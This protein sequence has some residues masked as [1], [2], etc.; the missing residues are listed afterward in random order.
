M[1]PKLALPTHLVLARSN[2]VPGA[3]VHRVFEA[4]LLHAITFH[5]RS[6]PFGTLTVFFELPAAAG[7]QSVVLGT[8]L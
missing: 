4:I 2:H 6:S 7:V 8:H 3:H 5:V 1:R